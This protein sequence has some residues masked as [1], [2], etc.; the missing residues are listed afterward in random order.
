M[1]RFKPALI[2]PS[3]G[4]TTSHWIHG[5]IVHYNLGLNLLKNTQCRG[6]KL[7]RSFI[8]ES[9]LGPRCCHRDDRKRT[10]GRAKCR[11]RT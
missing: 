5:E 1:L 8:F 6:K 10:A 11:S 7:F 3:A 9:E 4:N 2:S